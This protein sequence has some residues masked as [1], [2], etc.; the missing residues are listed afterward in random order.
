[1][2]T[3]QFA[4]PGVYYGLHDTRTTS[5]NDAFFHAGHYLKH[6]GIPQKKEE[7]GLYKKSYELICQ[8]FADG[9]LDAAEYMLLYTNRLNIFFEEYK[10]NEFG[11]RGTEQKIEHTRL[12]IIWMYFIKEKDLRVKFK[13][14]IDEWLQTMSSWLE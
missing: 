4:R 2:N 13:K 8:A 6:H 9:D 3:D 14:R 7:A 12:I 1:M 11:L 5:S 10:Y